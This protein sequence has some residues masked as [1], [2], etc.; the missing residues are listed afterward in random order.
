MRPYPLETSEQIGVEAL[1]IIVKSAREACGLTQ[2][3]LAR[4]AG[5]NQSTISRLETGR[6]RYLRF[7][8]LA[9]VFGILY[10]P[11]LGRAP[12]PNRWS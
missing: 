8:R 4:L 1:G 2:R 7:Q 9:T 6:L 3:H 11:M 5:M 12:R 10:D